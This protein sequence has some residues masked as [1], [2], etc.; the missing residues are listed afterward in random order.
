MQDG[1]VEDPLVSRSTKQPPERQHKGTARSFVVFLRT[2][3]HFCKT[4]PS[5]FKVSKEFVFFLPFQFNLLKNMIVSSF[6]LPLTSF[7]P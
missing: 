7:L 1:N 5:F 6:T 3:V 4:H 2:S